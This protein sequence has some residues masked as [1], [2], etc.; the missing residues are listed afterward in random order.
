MSKLGSL[1]GRALLCVAFVAAPCVLASQP[2]AFDELYDTLITRRDISRAR[3]L[4]EAGTPT[5]DA[6]EPGDVLLRGLAQY[7]SSS[8][9][10]EQAVSLLLANGVS[11]NERD[12]HGCTPMFPAVFCDNTHL[13]EVLIHNGADVSATNHNGVSLVAHAIQCGHMQSLKTLIENGAPLYSVDAAGDSTLDISIRSKNLN[14][15]RLL[16]ESGRPQEISADVKN[17][18]LLTAVAMGQLE[19]A[20]YLLQQH[21]DARARD[22]N[23]RSLLHRFVCKKASGATSP[24]ASVDFLVSSGIPV[25]GLDAC[26]NTALIL[27]AFHGS[28]VLVQHLVHNGANVNVTNAAGWTA[29]HAAA[30]AGGTGCASVLLEQG[31]DPGARDRGVT[32]AVAVRLL[33]DEVRDFSGRGADWLPVTGA[34]HTPIT[35]GLLAGHEDIVGM[36]WP[37]TEQVVGHGRRD[38][39][40]LYI[41]DDGAGTYLVF[42]NSMV[43]AGSA[44]QGASPISA[45]LRGDLIRI[46]VDANQYLY[47]RASGEQLRTIQTRTLHRPPI[48]FYKSGTPGAEVAVRGA[49]GLQC[50]QNLLR[51]NAAKEQAAM[52]HGWADDRDVLCNSVE[53]Q[54]VLAYMP[55]G[56]RPCCVAGGIYDWG[57]VGEQVLCSVHSG[58]VTDGRTRKLGSGSTWAAGPRQFRTLTAEETV[59]GVQTANCVNNL[60]I[61]DAAKE[62]CA[63][64]GGWHS[65]QPVSAGSPE[66]DAVLNYIHG[67]F[68]PAC[69]AGGRYEWNSIGMDPQCSVGGAHTL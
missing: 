36:L 26:G 50:G 47:L 23:G 42:S 4:L 15:L 39:D 61:L 6:G 49:G 68:M 69:P 18:A 56:K 59:N 28:Q 57:R 24:A 65:G 11:V 30:Y 5:T 37:T 53:E 21:F 2:G 7:R 54:S 32:P 33:A 9:F 29:L 1:R 63:Q 38:L 20:N 58:G 31:A 66:E 12:A 44:W 60:R 22:M 34:E 46:P 40:G 3:V 13:L 48:T 43:F 19:A 16:V 67:H 35:L 14:S 41:G 51:L 17:G 55:G 62:Q 52:E 45:E 27:A 8:N 10:V 25:D 64:E